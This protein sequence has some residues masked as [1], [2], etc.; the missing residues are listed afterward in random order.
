MNGVQKVE[1]GEF[2]IG[3]LEVLMDRKMLRVSR[4]CGLGLLITGTQNSG[5]PGVRDAILYS[6]RY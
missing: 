2:E 6:P 5:L 1:K 3:F 4:G